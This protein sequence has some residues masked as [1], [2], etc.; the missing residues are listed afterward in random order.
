ME[1]AREA[2]LKDGVIDILPVLVSAAPYALLI[3]ALAAQKGISPLEMLIMSATIFAG[4]SQFVAVSLWETPVPVLTL[5]FAAF[6]IN[7]RH[8]LMGVAFAPAI[9]HLPWRLRALM[10]HVMADEI[11][12][13]AMARYRRGGFSAAYYAGLS[14][15]LFS[16]WIVLTVTG[17]ILG[18][19]VPDPETYGIDFAFAGIFLFLLQAMI[20]ANQSNDRQAL[21]S[22]GIPILAAGIAAIATEPFLGSALSIL[23]GALAGVIAGAAVYREEER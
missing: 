17:N 13:I 21:R 22:V 11:W 19:L 18:G 7:T 10:A 1:E 16:A 14:L 6:V 4:G 23:I 8:I 9:Q 2:S 3:G 20:P 15:P 12:A 5:A